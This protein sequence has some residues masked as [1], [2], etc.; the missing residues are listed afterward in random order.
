MR[1]FVISSGFIRFAC[2]TSESKYGPRKFCT[3]TKKR[4]ETTRNQAELFYTHTSSVKITDVKPNQCRIIHPLL[5][6]SLSWC[7]NSVGAG[8]NKLGY[9]THQRNENRPPFL[10]KNFKLIPLYQ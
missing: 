4:H 9:G 8:V 5:S 2:H 6:V 3:E 1:S 10:K 7:G